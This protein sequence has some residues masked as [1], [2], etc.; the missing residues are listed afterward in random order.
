[1]V[2]GGVVGV[3]VGRGLRRVEGYAANFPRHVHLAIG[4][5][6]TWLRGGGLFGVRWA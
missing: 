6:A 2:E 5:E 4:L 1:M 3:F